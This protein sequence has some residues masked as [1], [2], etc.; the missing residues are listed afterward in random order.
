MHRLRWPARF[1]DTPSDGAIRVQ[2]DEWPP[3]IDL[4]AAGAGNALVPE[5]R[6]F[7]SSSRSAAALRL[8]RRVDQVR[9][10]F[11]IPDGR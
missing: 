9:G 3:V 2:V 6:D 11:R 10:S 4:V 5:G 7:P 1:V 8:R